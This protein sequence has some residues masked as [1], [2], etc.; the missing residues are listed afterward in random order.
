[1]LEQFIH[2]DCIVG[3]IHLCQ[4]H[5]IIFPGGSAWAAVI[6]GVFETSSGFRVEW[7]TKR[8][9]FNFYFSEV[10]WLVLTKFSFW[11]EDWELH[12]S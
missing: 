5:I 8:E 6:H 4:I 3:L 1:M 11:L 12:W 10:F 2:R 9:E 7:P